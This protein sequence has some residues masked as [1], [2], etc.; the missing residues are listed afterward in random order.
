MSEIKIITPG[1]AMDELG[2]FI[3]V[4]GSTE[5]KRK[6]R[7][8]LKA[9]KSGENWKDEGEWVVTISPPKNVVQVLDASNK[10]E[11]CAEKEPRR[12]MER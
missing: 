11:A 9:W 7:K 12:E 10:N 1:F 3:S 6:F 2:E 4:A 5:D 8:L